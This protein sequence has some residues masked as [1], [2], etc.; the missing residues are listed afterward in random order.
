MRLF[1]ITRG[2]A[3]WI[4]A[5]AAALGVVSAPTL[6][7]GK[8]GVV[9]SV[10]PGMLVFPFDVT[11]VTATNTAEVGS[12]MTDVAVS[13]AVLARAYQVSRFY[14]NYP[15]VARAVS[16]QQLNST[17][18]EAPY[19]EDNRKASKIIRAIGFEQGL[20][21]GVAEYQYDETK[22]EVTATVSGRVLQVTQDAVG[23]KIVK[24]GLGTAS[25]SKAGATEEELAVDA[26]RA[27]V[28]KLMGDLV[29]RAAVVAPEPGT[30]TVDTAKPKPAKKRR[31][32]WLWG[33]LAIGL[34]LGIA[35]HAVPARNRDDRLA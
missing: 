2:H 32:D 19:S 34:G 4:A 8:E 14:K 17:D 27:A 3:L 18:T 21:G 22:K 25:A 28:E 24:S 9:L 12:T 5:A 31:M 7:Q 16:E 20:V 30:K 1:P 13:R 23:Y 15:P 35:L 10:Q 6:A 26:C 11:G 33:T 29:P